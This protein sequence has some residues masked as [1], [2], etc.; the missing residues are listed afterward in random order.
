ML[1]DVALLHAADAR[2]LLDIEKGFASDLAVYVFHRQE[3]EAIIPDLAQAFPW[4][5][6]ITNVNQAEGLIAGHVSRRAG[7]FYLGM[8]PAVLA[9]IL[10]VISEVKGG[11]RRRYEAGLLKA[12]GWTTKDIVYLY[13]ARATLIGLPSV[14]TGLAIAF[15]LVFRPGISWPGYL[16]FGWEKNAPPLFLDPNGSMIIVVQILAGVFLPYLIANLWPAVTNAATDPMEMI[17]SQ[18]G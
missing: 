18:E 17:E 4:P 15:C 2:R 8:I 11:L 12:F 5:V 13:M 10:L 6:Q 9:M 7:L 3:A 14:A 16:L 1:H